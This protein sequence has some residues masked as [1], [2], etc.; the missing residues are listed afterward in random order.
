MISFPLLLLPPGTYTYL[1]N[2][3]FEL[4]G[5]KVYHQQKSILNTFSSLS[6]YIQL[7]SLPFPEDS[8]SHPA[9]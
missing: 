4:S 5:I 9:L 8:A 6:G 7:K 3:S 2:V 1:Q